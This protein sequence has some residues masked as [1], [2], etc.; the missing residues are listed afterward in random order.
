MIDRDKQ[1]ARS[2]LP[3]LG[4]AGRGGGVAV[5]ACRGLTTVGVKSMSP[6]KFCEET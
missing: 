2:S 5:I 1:F 3:P 6:V 4:K